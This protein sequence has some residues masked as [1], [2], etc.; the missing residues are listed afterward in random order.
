MSDTLE[1]QDGAM[2]MSARQ[3]IQPRKHQPKKGP[4]IYG[5][6]EAKHRHKQDLL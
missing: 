4:D 6:L 5:L 1:E 2:A 3:D